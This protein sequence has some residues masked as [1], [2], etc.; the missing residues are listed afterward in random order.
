MAGGGLCLAADAPRESAA[1]KK[2][3]VFATWPFN[4]DEA[5]RRQEETAKALGIPKVQDVDLGDGVKITM[6]LIPAGKYRMGDSPG[7]DAVI[8]RPFYFGKYDVTQAQYV[9]VVG[10][11]PSLHRGNTNPADTIQWEEAA[12]FCKQASEKTKKT[13]Y[14]PDE[15]QW[16]W[17]CRAG[18]TTLRYW[19]D[20]MKDIGD[21]CWWHDNCAMHTHPVGQ[22]KPNAF[23]LYDMMGNVW[24]WCRD[25]GPEAGTHPVR[26]ATFG[27]RLPMFKT[28]TRSMAGAGAND[29]YGFRVAMEVE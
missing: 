15:A 25:G 11:N 12:E 27:S 7:R 17:A 24:E 19:G 28:T 21:Y 26:G 8:A 14:L 16:E 18:T 9:A 2:A 10:K 4:A 13:F 1:G 20:D 5:A 23:G 3:E 29:R 22:K 6:I